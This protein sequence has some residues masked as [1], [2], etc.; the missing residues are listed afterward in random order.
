MQSV[1]SS[2]RDHLKQV[3]NKIKASKAKERK[4]MDRT[5]RTHDGAIEGIEM[6]ARGG[7]KKKK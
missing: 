6:S 4:D 7:K 5:L 1:A 3:M 2:D